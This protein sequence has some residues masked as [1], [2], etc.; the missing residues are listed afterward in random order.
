MFLRVSLHAAQL[1]QMSVFVFLVS[2]RLLTCLVDS[3]WKAHFETQ[4]SCT[5]ISQQI[6]TS[7]KKLYTKGVIGND[8][9]IG[10]APGVVVARRYNRYGAEIKI[11]SRIDDG[12]T[13]WVVICRGVE[14][15]VKALALDHT[16]PMR[17]D[18]STLSTVKL[19][20]FSMEVAVVR[21]HLIIIS[22]WRHSDGTA[23]V[24]FIPG[25]HRVDDSRFS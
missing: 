23:N 24:A 14:R 21:V 9:R 20:A 18:E 16:E 5:P 17:V 15:Y 8:T 10:P 12:T 3:S 6:H 13:C 19:V 25:I 2:A 4:N 7:M 22:T 11:D 1:V